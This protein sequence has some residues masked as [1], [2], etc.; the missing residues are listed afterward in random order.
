MKKVLV[1]AIAASVMWLSPPDVSA[2]NYYVSPS[3]SDT[4]PGTSELPFETIQK[5]ADIV[6]AGD[7]VI[8]RDGVYTDS[9]DYGDISNCIV[10]LR[11]DGTPTDWITFRAENTHGAVLDGNNV[12]NTAFY[13]YRADYIHIEGFEIKRVGG[14]HCNNSHDSYIYKC[15]IHDIGRYYTSPAC[16]GYTIGFAGISSTDTVYNVTVDSCMFYDIGRQHQD[17]YCVDDYKY[18]QMLYAQGKGWLIKNNIFYNAP[19]GWALKLD[20]HDGATSEPTH[21]VINNTFA[22]DTNVGVD[23]EG[24]I[25][26]VLSHGDY[27]SSDL[28]IQNNI[29]YN[30]PGSSA[31]YVR[32]YIDLAGSIF[33]NNVTSS[34]DLW[35]RYGGSPHP[36]NPTESDNTTGL[37]LSSFNLT[38]PENNDFTLTSSA[39]YLIDNGIAI[40]APDY[41][42]AGT[43]RPYG[44]GYD[45]GAYE[46]T[47]VAYFPIDRTNWS[48]EFVDSEE[49][50]G[51]DGEAE[52]S[53]DGDPDTFWCT[54]WTPTSPAHPHE[55]QIDLGGFYDICGFRYLPRQDVGPGDENGMIDE[56][57][58]YVSSD[59][60]DWGTAVASGTW[61]AGKMEKQVLFGCTLG[62]YVRLIALSEVNGN[63]WTSMAELNVLAVQPDLDIN[64]DGKVNIEDFA[65]LA[66]WWDDENAC[67]SPDWCEG[68][69][70]DMNGMVN[71]LDLAY[72]VEN[73]LRH[74]E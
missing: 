44:D 17:P 64:N 48:V 2:I 9:N 47:G 40:D 31:I 37:S 32:Y 10:I 6:V 57:E 71:M 70:F 28:V 38:D 41:D 51:D 22:H 63:P 61:T 14:V 67:S 12:R 33:R 26:I 18:D 35:G 36:S 59:T 16:N 29:F 42:Y 24:H 45:I 23:A 66:A 3:G 20:G 55:I 60:A 52:N 27:P 74:G 19:S 69:D 68:A 49:T 43:S 72:F 39:A 8:V 62:Q 13:L 15:K 34:S 53:F 1:F 11:R 30:P 21:K 4:N 25:V 50:I 7:T 54:Q 56:Y 5:A 65:I 58:F 46:F 73:W